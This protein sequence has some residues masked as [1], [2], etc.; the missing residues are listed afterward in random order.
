MTT[1]VPIELG[2][3]ELLGILRHL[4]NGWPAWMQEAINATR[5]VIEEA[6][7]VIPAQLADD[8][9]Q[10]DKLQATIANL[11]DQLADG[12][13]DSPAV[14]GRLREAEEQIESVRK[15]IDAANKMLTNPIEMPSDEWIADQL[16][17]L[18]ALMLEATPQRRWAAAPHAWQGLGGSRGSARQAAGYSAALRIDGLAV[19]L[20]AL[21]TKLSITTLA[22]INRVAHG[23]G[24]S[25]ELVL[26]LGGPSRMDY[27][28]PKIAEMRAA[29]CRG[30]RSG[31][32]RVWAVDRRTWRGSAMLNAQAKHESEHRENGPEC[33]PDENTGSEAA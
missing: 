32:S 10:L 22:Q 23:Q 15:R 29:A 4:L 19:L 2:E 24:Q 18:P 7:M 3:A 25:D 9:R 21:G 6:S 28:G 16:R 33:P 1:M 5:K 20:A 11:V 8:Q 12:T 14:R 13:F 31:G 17:D 30:K 26:D 27:W